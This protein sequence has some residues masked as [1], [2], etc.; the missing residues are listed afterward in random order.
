[1]SPLWA[2]RVALEAGQPVLIGM[3]PP[4]F[5]AAEVVAVVVA[6]PTQDR[7]EPMVEQR[8]AVRLELA[9]K[10]GM[11]ESLEELLELMQT[12]LDTIE[13]MAEVAV[14]V[15]V[16]LSVRL[17]LPEELPELVLLVS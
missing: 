6:V 13:A 17:Q 5:L 2:Q 1:M 7:L 16:T 15:E 4:T 8:Q 11:Q 9:A 12:P 10:A 3:E 14:A